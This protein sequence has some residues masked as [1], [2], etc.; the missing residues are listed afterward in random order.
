MSRLDDLLTREGMDNE[1]AGIGAGMWFATVTKPALL[2]VTDPLYVDIPEM[3]ILGQVKW[4][5]CRWNSKLYG[6]TGMTLPVVGTE[7]L[8]AFD[9][10]QQ[11]WV[12]AI[13]Q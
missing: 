3:S 6:L 12:V 4:G 8:V 7:V 2:A 5:P 13:W 11:P 9:N 1:T 10:R